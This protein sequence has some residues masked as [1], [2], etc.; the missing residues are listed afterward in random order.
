MTRMAV[1]CLNLRYI[2]YQVMI[3]PLG[4][5]DFVRTQPWATVQH[6]RPRGSDSVRIFSI[7]EWG[8]VGGVIAEISWLLINLI[9][10]L[11]VKLGNNLSQ[12]WNFKYAFWTQISGSRWWFSWTSFWRLLKI[13]PTNMGLLWRYWPKFG[14][15]LKKQ[16]YN[17]TTFATASSNFA[18][19]V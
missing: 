2:A 17:K 10:L 4:P 15:L 1:N 5:Q 6:L 14:H 8:F 13:Q 12:C 7:P 9:S 19:L 11:T 3:N 16:V 18:A